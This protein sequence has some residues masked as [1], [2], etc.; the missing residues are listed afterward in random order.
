[1][2]NE[3]ANGSDEASNLESLLEPYEISDST[4]VS[5]LGNLIDQTLAESIRP[6]SESS[7]N[8]FASLLESFWR[9]D[10]RLRQALRLCLGDFERKVREIGFQAWKRESLLRLS[11]AVSEIDRIVGEQLNECLHHPRLQAL[12]ASWRGLRMLVDVAQR[13]GSRKVQIRVLNVSWR[14]VQRDFE[15]ASEFDG[16]ELFQKVYENEFGTPGGTPF[17]VLVGD[18]EIHPRPTPQHPFDDIAILGQ[19]AGVAAAAFCPLVCGASPELF[20]VDEFLDL[21]HTQDLAQG[22]QLAEFI[23]WRSLR[24]SEDARF[25]GLAMP[26]IL[27]R[28][29][30]TQEDVL[31]FC[32]EEQT[33]AK[34]V[35]NYLW[36]N[37][38]YAWSSVLIRSYSRTG[39][40]ADIR[41]TER[42][43]DGGGLVANLPSCSFGTDREG[44]ALRSTTDLMITDAQ[45]AELA[46]LGFLPLC[47][48]HDTNL[49]AFYSSQSIQKP[50]H[51]DSPIASANAN[52]SA[53]L[54]Y[55]LCVSRFAHYLKVIA[56]DNVGA[57]LE[58]EDMQAK[59]DRWI[60]N[61]VT[62]DEHARPDVKAKRPLRRA[63]VKVARDQSRPGNY[64][65]Q[66]SLL[67]HYQ[68][69]DLSASIRLQ[70]KLDR[71]RF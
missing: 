42:D 57:A 37:A 59:L 46:K 5:L 43:L 63:E 31:G 12:E 16:S 47:H 8:A 40:L 29:P 34:H 13:E 56:R 32:F 50:K 22:F 68:L 10:L 66:F 60:K 18:Y 33:K 55:I 58:P 53:M 19:L 11:R 17:S 71:P 39:W 36:G 1:M 45:E 24:Q 41:G 25:V 15:R 20:G 51:Y 38:A 6:T 35:G 44:V 4:S 62:P 65:C 70:T 26:R 2:Q 67:P 3:T 14:E 7:E 69:D 30:Y 28:S 52:I 61:Y 49:A 21:Q 23:K 64:L 48:C 9:G 27:M 54:H